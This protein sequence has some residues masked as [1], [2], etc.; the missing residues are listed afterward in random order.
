[1]SVEIAYDRSLVD[2]VAARFDLREPNSMALAALIERIADAQGEYRELVAD[3]AT[4]VGKTFLMA[5]LVDYLA[6]QGVRHVLVVT[7]GSTIQRKT[8]D[9]FD[10]ANAKYVP[11]ADVVPTLIT[12][13][14]FQRATIGSALRD[15]TNL[16]V[17]VFN[18]Q[19]LVRP[20][21]NASRRVRENDENI[22]EALYS[23][24]AQAEDLVVIADEHHVYHARAQ[25]FHAAIR[26][27]GPRALVGLT[28]T[29]NP[30]DS[31]KI[32]FR[33]TLGEAIADGHVK[34]PV[35]VYRKDGTRDERTQLADACQ[36]LRQKEKAYAAYREANP[37]SPAVKPALFVVTQSIDHSREV[38][39]L[40]AQTGYIGDPQAI[41][42]VTSEA[43]DDALRELA[44][45]EQAESPIR[46]IVS[47]NMLREGWDVRNIAVIV[48]LRRLASQTL[49]EQILG[50]GLR[51]PFGRRTGIPVVDQVDL[52]AHD[53]YRQLLD[54]KDVLRQ[55]IAS[56]ASELEVDD[57]GAA[58]A[59]AGGEH[60]G[61]GDDQVTTPPSTDTDP[62]DLVDVSPRDADGNP[63]APQLTFA[64]TD[65]R[66]ATPTPAPIGRAEGAPQIIFPHREA[67]LAFAT[68]TLSD[69]PNAD[70]R[71]AGARFIKEVPTFIYR[72]ALE[73]RRSGTEIEISV[74]P[75]ANAE[76]QQQLSGLD[77][78]RDDLVAS[79]LNQ[80]EVTRDRSAR[81]A[82]ERLVTA[83]L[84][85]AGVTSDDAA[86]EWGELRR[87][88]AVD[89]M[90]AMIRSAIGRRKREMTYDLVPVTLPVEPILPDPDPRNAY[91]DA[92]VRGAQ[93]SGWRKSVLPVASF[94]AKTT[95]WQLAHLLDRDDEI[96]W[97]LRLSVT[98]PAYISHPNGSYFPDFVAIDREGTHWL[99]EGKSDRNAA[100]PDVVSKRDAAE[101]WA[102]AVRDD[103]RHGVWRYLFATESAIAGA[104]GAWNGLVIAAAP[105]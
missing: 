61:A 8:L 57:H 49:T 55:R 30:D 100:D 92:F 85:G 104:A 59:P 36:L 34:V 33:Y 12:P 62:G 11:G 19:Q 27:L 78:V 68:F 29:P 96:A 32:A 5:A 86:A 24:L 75:Q 54:Q 93:F 3:L 83:F 44:A 97:W 89:G 80:A 45:V 46:A 25:A 91:N 14:N 64:E 39:Q 84:A 63:L 17:F 42:E 77:V 7:P 40:L 52:V 37:D 38:G 65:R 87:R 22:G 10:R 103:G 41:L 69:V 53:S 16:K 51:L 71:S 35:I 6:I 31:D 88:Q 105:E 94:D 76:A 13:D 74:T 70:A 26:D 81:N 73:A 23:Q 67:Q 48:A 60:H 95:E 58:P 102:R 9:N 2:E 50:R 90:R 79:V 43:S 28:A 72:D 47:V 56:P 18:V 99:I 4:G 66:L 1:M 101:Q 21:D 82:A 98:D 20:T 15:S